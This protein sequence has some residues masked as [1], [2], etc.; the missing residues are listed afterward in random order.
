MAEVIQII[1]CPECGAEYTVDFGD[2][3]PQQM[4]F[5]GACGEIMADPAD[6]SGWN[7]DDVTDGDFAGDYVDDDE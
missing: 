2:A 1:S 7:D 6:Q 4:V 3:P 5:C